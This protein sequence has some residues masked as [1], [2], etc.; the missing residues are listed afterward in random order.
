MLPNTESTHRA[1]HEMLTFNQTFKSSSKRKP[2]LDRETFS[3][4][5]K[6]KAPDSELGIADYQ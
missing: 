2:L 3:F 5:N 4:S 6:G 1:T